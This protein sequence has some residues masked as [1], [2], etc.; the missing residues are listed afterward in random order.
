M[1]LRLGEVDR[2]K[3]TCQQYLRSSPSMI[4]LWV[5]YSWIEQVAN[6]YEDCDKVF[7]TLIQRFPEQYTSWHAYALFLLTYKVS[8]I[9]HLF[10]LYLPPHA[11]GVPAALE[12]ISHS[13][14]RFLPSKPQLGQ[15]IALDTARTAFR[16]L[17]QLPCGENEIVLQQQTPGLWHLVIMKN[18][19]YY[20]HQ[21]T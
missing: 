17:L 14:A 13:I 8:G 11:Q 6:N 3:L 9:H 21:S 20:G 7:F 5:L 1:E 12:V 19:A 2:C 4:E 10:K 15:T 16:T 18:L